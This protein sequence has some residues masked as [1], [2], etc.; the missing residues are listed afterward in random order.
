MAAAEARG[1]EAVY[2]AAAPEPDPPD[3]PLVSGELG[4]PHLLSTAIQCRRIARCSLSLP[5]ETLVAR[6]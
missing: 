5:I 2:V 3:D 1:R 6:F 4:E